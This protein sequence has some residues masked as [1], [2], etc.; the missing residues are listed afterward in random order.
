MPGF[1][2]IPEQ[3]ML[4]YRTL[5]KVPNSKNNVMPLGMEQ[6][7]AWLREKHY[8]ADALA[9]GSTV[10]LAE[11]VEGTIVE[12]TDHDGSAATRA[13]IVENTARGRWTSQ[14]TIHVPRA[15]SRDPWV[16]LDVNAPGSE[17]AASH[18]AWTGTPGLARRL[19]SVMPAFDESA[20][21]TERPVPVFG[22]EAERLVDIVCDPDRRGLVFVAGSDDAMP[23]PRWIGLVARL[24][25]DTVGLAAGYVLDAAATRLLAAALGP[26]HAVAP[27]TVRTFLPGADPA[28]D[29]DSLRHRVLTTQR[30]LR[31]DGARVARLLGWQAREAALER[32]LPRYAMR[33]SAHLEQRLDALLTDRLIIADEPDLTAP[34]DLSAPQAGP[35]SDPDL[36]AGP[37]GPG[38]ADQASDWLTLR[39]LA[40]TVLGVTD[41]SEPSLAE[42]AR[43]AQLG[44]QAASTQAAVSERLQDLQARATLAEEA[45]Q[46]LARRLE[47]EQLEHAL[48]A[49][50]GEE[51]ALQLQV[52]NGQLQHFRQ[53]LRQNGRAA[54]AWTPPSR[55]AEAARPGSFDDLLEMLSELEHIVFTGNP[56]VTVTLDEYDPLGTWAGKSWDALLAL[57]DYIQASRAKLCDRDVDGYLRNTPAGYWPFPANRHARDESD[58]VRN[59]ARFRAARMLPVPRAI[60]ACG[61][62]FMGAHFKIAQSGMISPRLYY[63]DAKTQ[64]GSIY[65]GYIG[66]H[67]PTKRTN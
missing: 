33:V 41:F 56:E 27:G 29:L 52:A 39:D 16:L 46:E 5:F 65:V 66:K 38:V 18:P 50:T 34:A 36:S 4:G 58:D 30:I 7:H 62:T 19:L 24:L 14:L 55:M 2:T 11:N 17:A 23:L 15:A 37:A 63:L 12:Y 60:H 43:L 10:V 8:A 32:P 26:S 47:D 67:L 31:D 21:L 35:A 42:I 40:L 45:R 57:N 1:A 61:Q 3:A 20:E 9:P 13:R 28:S 6:L 22:E 48:A 59:N 25:S 54:A 51:S 53:L 44:K 64:A 49:Q